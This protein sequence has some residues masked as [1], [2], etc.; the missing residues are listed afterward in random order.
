MKSIASLIFDLRSEERT[1]ETSFKTMNT[2]AWAL[3]RMSQEIRRYEF[4]AVYLKSDKARLLLK[5]LEEFFDDFSLDLNVLDDDFAII[6]VSWDGK[7]FLEKAKISNRYVQSC[8]LI[9]LFDEDCPMS[10][11]DFH[12]KNAENISIFSIDDDEM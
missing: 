6:S 4:I 7:I 12:S 3:K 9:T 11:L 1:Q 8:A 5:E 10:M 2:F